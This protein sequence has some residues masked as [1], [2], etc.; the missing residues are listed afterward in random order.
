MSSQRVLQEGMTGLAYGTC[1]VL[2]LGG[3]PLYLTIRWLCVESSWQQLERPGLIHQSQGVTGRSE[4]HNCFSMVFLIL[5]DRA[6]S[7]HVGGHPDCIWCVY[8][9]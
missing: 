7:L 1:L 2:R 5:G 8:V 4:A 6:T 3:K 9:G